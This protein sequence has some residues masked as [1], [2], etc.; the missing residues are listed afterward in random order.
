MEQVVICVGFYP[1]RQVIAVGYYVRKWNGVPQDYSEFAAHYYKYIESIVASFPGFARDDIKDI[2][3]TIVMQFIAG[4]YL[5]IYSAEKQSAYAE[6]RYKQQLAKFHAGE[7]DFAPVKHAGKFSSYLYEFTK[8]RLLG[9]R[10]KSNRHLTMMKSI[11]DFISVETH[12]GEEVSLLLFFGLNDAEFQN[13]EV[14]QVLKQAYSYLCSLTTPTATK[15]FP[16]LF[17]AA[18][19]DAFNRDEGFDREAYA[20]GRN[21]TPSAVSMQLKEMRMFLQQA[22]FWGQLKELLVI[23]HRASGNVSQ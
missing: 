4:D 2:T 14:R 22:G 3:Q 17:R 13:I 11:E 5:N 15:D 6:Q 9:I 1:T 21:I 19:D 8:L 7:L 20:R 10:D 12:D 16:S 18:V 23:R